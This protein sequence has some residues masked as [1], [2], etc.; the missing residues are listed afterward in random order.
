MAIDKASS[1]L[2]EVQTRPSEVHLRMVERIMA[3]EP[4]CTKA[5]TKKRCQARETKAEHR[6]QA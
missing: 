3:M 5:D 6:P 1:A 4:A 2:E